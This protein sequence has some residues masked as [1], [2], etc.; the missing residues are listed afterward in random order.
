M[1]RHI[2]PAW[3]RN[4]ADHIDG[5]WLVIRVLFRGVWDVI[6]DAYLTR[7][8]ALGGGWY[9]MYLSLNY[10]FEAG[11]GSEWNAGTIAASMAILT[12]MSALLIFL[13]KQY[14]EHKHKAKELEAVERDKAV[15]RDAR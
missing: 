8:A 7:R 13:H 6:D 12:P 3:Y 4:A 1:A 5:H 10:C 14:G 9:F 2:P 11:R 15:E